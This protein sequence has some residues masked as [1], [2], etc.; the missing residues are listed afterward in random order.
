MKTFHQLALGVIVLLVSFHSPVA[1]RPVEWNEAAFDNKPEA[2]KPYLARETKDLSRAQSVIGQ[3]T[4]YEAQEKDTFL[5]V[6]RYYSLGHNEIVDANPGVDEW[7]PPPGQILLLPTE[8]VLPDTSYTGIKVNIPEM[9]LYYFQAFS[10][11]SA[12]VVTYPVGLGRDEWRTPEGKFKVRGKTFNPTWVLPESIKAEHRRMGKP[13]PDFIA[14]GAPD[15]PLGH[16]RLELT[17]GLYAIHGTNIPWGVGMQVS[18]G[19]VR[20]YPEDIE[21]LFELIPVGTVGEFLYQ[22][23]KVGARDGRIYLEVHKDIYSLR[24]GLYQEAQRLIDKNGWRDK[25]DMRRVGQ[26]VQEQSGVAIDV[27][28]DSGNDLPEE[29]L[30]EIRPR[31]ASVQ[32]PPVKAAQD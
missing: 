4:F 13:A 21:R 11:G 27:T 14:G 24:P 31:T 1:A 10:P 22:P 3:T 17:L 16:H 9:R 8:F 28:L 20:L 7:V 5:D 2:G 29:N 12:M 19:C 15:N 30:R 32:R 26:V 18:H 6:A 25:V 23:V